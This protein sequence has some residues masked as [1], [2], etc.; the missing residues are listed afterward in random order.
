M[1]PLRLFV[2]ANHVEGLNK[3]LYEIDPLDLSVKSLMSSDL[4]V[5]LRKASIGDPQWV[6]D[7]ACIVAFCADMVSP[8]Q[9]FADQ[10]PYGLRGP[11]YVYLE[12]G[13]AAQNLQLQ[14]VSEELGSVWVGGFDDEATAEILG[15]QA[16]V[17]P[18]I[19]MCVGHAASED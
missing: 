10:K 6:T 11:R 1:H 12:A 8:S 2:V 5:A 3:G 18:I 9:A 13:A 7:A 16:P 15:L 14:A 4:R 17:T 19:L